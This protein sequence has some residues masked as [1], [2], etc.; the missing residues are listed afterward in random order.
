MIVSPLS[1][2]ARHTEKREGD[3]NAF[4]PST[5]V[6]NNILRMIKIME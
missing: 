2:A 6:A 3:V 1:P 5:N 4:V